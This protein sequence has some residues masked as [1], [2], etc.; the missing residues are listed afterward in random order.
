MTDKI[1]KDIEVSLYLVFNWPFNQYY[2]ESTMYW[3]MWYI[4]EYKHGQEI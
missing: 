1:F 2:K 3:A 4:I